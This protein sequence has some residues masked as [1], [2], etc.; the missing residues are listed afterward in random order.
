MSSKSASSQTWARGRGCDFCVTAGAAYRYPARSVG[1]GVLIKR[2]D[3]AHRVVWRRVYGPIPLG[4]NGKPLKVDELCRS[5]VVCAARPPGPENE[6]LEHAA[7]RTDARAQQERPR[8][9]NR[10]RQKSNCGT[11]VLCLYLS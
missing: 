8:P 9:V 6:A 10:K 3:T 5:D 1:L 11:N 4:P 7:T 2:S